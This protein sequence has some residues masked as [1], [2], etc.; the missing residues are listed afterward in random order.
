MRLSIAEWQNLTAEAQLDA[1]PGVERGQEAA[2]V[3]AARPGARAVLGAIPSLALAGDTAA[4]RLLLKRALERGD[5]INHA[6]EL[7]RLRHDD[8]D[9]LSRL[10]ENLCWQRRAA[11]NWDQG[12]HPALVEEYPAYQLKAT[13]GRV[14]PGTKERW[15]QA[16][17]RLFGG[18]MVALKTDPVWARF[19]IFGRPY[20]PYDNFSHRLDVEEVDALT[21]AR[22]GIVCR[23]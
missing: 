14:K 7:S 9:H 3:A 5:W 1:W 8:G 6:A 13:T 10:I 17:G 22:L 2:F 16:G 21:A 15:V 12:M 4:D 11:E 19:S 20:P 18:K 23:S